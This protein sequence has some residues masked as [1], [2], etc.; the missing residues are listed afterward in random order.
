VTVRR[1]LT[2]ICFAAIVALGVELRLLRMPFA[3]RG[4][5]VATYDG[6]YDRQW[7]TYRAFL[8]GVRAHTKPGD[9]ITVIVPAMKWDDGY[10]YAYYRASYYL[11]GRVVLPVVGPENVRYQENFRAARYVAE[12]GVRL[13]IPADV[14][15][16]GN[17]G[18][19]VR[20]RQ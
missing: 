1:A 8:A 10:S 11:T 20:L 17:D 13:P 5:L 3:D 19:L 18:A 14:I 7:P 12:F 9:T 4:P 6:F 16:Q 15:W 2:A